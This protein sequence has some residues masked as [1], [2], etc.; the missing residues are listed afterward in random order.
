MNNLKA[1]TM[2]SMT[3][4]PGLY[5]YLPSLFAEA[6]LSVQ[7]LSTGPLAR[8]Y[9][10]RVLLVCFS[11]Q[12]SLSGPAPY[13]YNLDR[14]SCHL[15]DWFPQLGT[16]DQELD[17]VVEGL[18]IHNDAALAVENTHFRTFVQTMIDTGTLVSCPDPRELI[19]KRGLVRV[20]GILWCA[21]ALERMITSNQSLGKAGARQTT[22]AQTGKLRPSPPRSYQ[23]ARGP[24]QAN[25]AYEALQQKEFATALAVVQLPPERTQPAAAETVQ[26][27]P[28]M[29]ESINFKE[30]A[31]IPDLPAS[32]NPQTLD[33]DGESMSHSPSRR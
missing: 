30:V 13:N 14:I 6:Q 3:V 17:V 28:E 29:S 19:T 20:Y 24:G 11:C 15:T 18:D 32:M 26:S 21:P 27:T 31:P 1:Y 33:R 9:V 2:S 10:P 12:K 8:D 7:K 5:T 23:S 4:L 22:G 25:Q 16:P